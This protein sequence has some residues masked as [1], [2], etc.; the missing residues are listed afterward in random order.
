MLIF[1]M[2]R[3]MIINIPVITLNINI[4]AHKILQS[5]D[6]AFTNFFIF[7]KY[8]VWHFNIFL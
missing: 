2:S 3:Y 1:I 8:S 5:K 6:T 4:R 7:L